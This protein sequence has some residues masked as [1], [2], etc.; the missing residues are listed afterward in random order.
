[1]VGPPG[2]GKSDITSVIRKVLSAKYGEEFGFHS[3]LLTTR[4]AQDVGG[5]LLPAKCADGTTTAIYTRSPL[6]PSREY[7][8]AHKR[9]LY[10]L[11]ERN[12][13]EL[14]MQK[15]IAPVVLWKRFGGENLPEGWWIL[16]ASNRTEDR[17][18]VIKPPAFL[19]NRE[20]TIAIDPD[21]GSWSVWAEEQG[22]H[23]MFIAFAKQR[24][25]VVFAGGVPKHE[26]PF[27]TA[28]SF[29][30]AA[31]LMSLV[32][33]TDANGNLNMDMPTDDLTSQ[34][35]AGHIGEGATAEL[36][37]F[38]KLH[39]H[40]PE[41]TEIEKDPSGAKCPERLDAAF[42]AVQIC[43]HYAKANNIDKLWTYVERLPKEVQVMAAKSLIEKSG[44]LLINSKS[45]TTWMSKNRALINASAA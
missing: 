5:F 32:A 17:S 16:S 4:D 11:D 36:F 24:P 39:E 22:L 28:R 7:L 1:M 44:G 29:T 42:A 9:G 43:I 18:G 41:I 13:S 8:A 38:L 40:L 20:V 30:E 34:M 31:N 27:C 35:I 37:S 6:L 26:G 3:E 45:L 19:V 15:A 21:V 25:G 12:Q 2:C 33:G 23:P 10:F 14:L